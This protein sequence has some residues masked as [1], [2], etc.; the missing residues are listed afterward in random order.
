MPERS[1]MLGPSCDPDPL[2]IDTTGA[3][4]GDVRETDRELTPDKNPHAAELGR[5]GGKKGGPARAIK[6][7]A[8]RRREIAR[9]AAQAR[10]HGV[11]DE[12]QGG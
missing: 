8:E 3:A 11:H 6:L 12:Q 1:S 7:S 4:P 10:W 9:K 5:L 2:S